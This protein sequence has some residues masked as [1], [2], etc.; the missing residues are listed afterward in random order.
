MA[1]KRANT[2]TKGNKIEVKTKPKSMPLM[3]PEAQFFQ[4]LV[5]TSNRFSALKKQKEGYEFGI[6]KLELLRKKIQK[7]QI[8]P[9]ILLPFIPKHSFYYEYDKKEILKLLDEQLATLKNSIKSL[10][11]Q[12]QHRYDEYAE[13]AQR[14]K[15]FINKRYST[16]GPQKISSKR[17]E[18]EE[19]ETLF[20]AEFKELMESEE[21]KEE[22][23]KAK[24]EAIKKNVERQK[25]QKE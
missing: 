20:E 12:M 22:F 18:S 11:G 16:L 14:S 25:K 1:R 23:K 9:P 21:K 15:D 13:S 17:Q 19:E 3:Q 2:P 4:E 5:D 10:E 8:K 6:G 7:D 24:M